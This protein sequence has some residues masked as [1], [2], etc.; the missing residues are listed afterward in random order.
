VQIVPQKKITYVT[1]LA[2]ESIHPKYEEALKQVAKDFGKHHAMYIGG[3]KV[4]AGEGEF[5]HHSPIDTSI[6]IGHFQ[7]GTAQHARKAIS[8]A[9][10]FFQDWSS[11]PWKERVS[12]IRKA[13][14]ILEENM[15]YIA[16]L[17]TYEV[18][19]NRFE[20]I[21][22]ASEGV[23]MLRY[24]AQLME[25]ND[26]YVKPMQPGA[27]N[28]RSQSVLRPYGVWAVVSPFNFPLAL[29]A[30]MVA[31]ALVTGN[32]VVFKPTSEAPLS[33]LKLYETLV[34]AGVPGGVINF[35]TGPGE[36][37]GNEF[38]SNPDVMGIAFTGSKDVGM[39]LYR[40]FV[41]KQAY[42]KPFIAEMGSKNP[43]IITAKADLQKAAE[44]VVRGAYG[45][46]GQKCSATSRVYVER[47][48]KNDFLKILK[49]K[50]EDVKVGDPREKP[51]FVGPVV[52]EKAVKKYNRA[53]EQ[54]KKDGGK[55]VAEASFNQ[56][57]LPKGYYV[58]P[59]AITG[60]PPNHRL[61]KEE[62]FVPFVAV[63]EFKTIDEALDKANDT[64]FGLTAGIFSEDEKE[65]QYFFK[66]IDFGVTYANR[67]GGATTGAWPGAQ[68]FGGWKGSGATG[69]GVG[70]PYYL[71]EFMH[72]QAQ[73]VVT[74]S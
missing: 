73:T 56:E 63:D 59:V 29:A 55:V 62:L 53:L 33:A 47:G 23:D 54:A 24:Y 50:I 34:Q 21:A 40:E 52:N 10:G 15:F 45:Y 37:F 4:L 65:K 74:D 69:K 48:I 7:K 14:D 42:P 68:S 8:V 67:K 26:G 72:E 38:T 43:A 13:A 30:G 60:L 11:R 35:L 5:E 9:K 17:I 28:E 41:N 36:A 49:N 6:L 70:G 51:V 18:G 1:L 12:I 46:G 66:N 58:K 57:K 20:A 44:G 32:T 31:G 22:E 3:R 2:D 27:A 16:A 39:Q 71:L 64:E 25:E 19:K 61:L